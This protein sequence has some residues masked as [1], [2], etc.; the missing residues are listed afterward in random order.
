MNTADTDET[1]GPRLR[2]GP[3]PWVIV[4]VLVPV[5]GAMAVAFLLGQALRAPDATAFD[6][7][8]RT[9][10]TTGTVEKRAL[11]LPSALGTVGGSTSVSVHAVAPAGAAAAQI[12]AAPLGS[13]A[14]VT[15]GALLFA[16][17]ERP[18]FALAIDGP[19]YRDLVQGD[20][21]EDVLA[22]NGA[23]SR[24]GYAADPEKATF[25]SATVASLAAFYDDRGY[26]AQR[27]PDVVSATPASTAP[28]GTLAP[29][30]TPAPA[31]T[32]APTTATPGPRGGRL[33]FSEIVDL[34][35]SDFTVAS[36]PSLYS[37]V[38]ADGQ[39]MTWTVPP[40]RVVARVDVASADSLTAGEAASIVDPA[41]AGH[42][43][44]VIESIGPFAPSADKS[45]PGH[46][47]T[48]I[49]SAETRPAL[50]S[51]ASVTV[52]FGERGA[53]RL[54]VPATALRQDGTTSFVNV[55]RVGGQQ[56]VEINVRAVADGWA[57]L[58]GEPALTVGE[59]VVI[60]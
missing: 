18:V 25:D 7:A 11:P 58:D 10:T 27:G 26:Q 31:A 8:Q 40:D 38:P 13:G 24:L 59:T 20:E 49:V 36:A 48:V 55:D 2:L 1:R 12:T 57:L 30:A 33:P 29:A 21:G 47:V 60:G 39:V 16:V 56:R 46:D 5:I 3:R 19:R 28:A 14:A 4:V 44:G 51:G 41:S 53:E 54:A 32:Q 37:T 9:L 34:D 45:A 6:N 17:A 23:L 42:A 15:D 35:R 52:T 22:L 43:D 50:H